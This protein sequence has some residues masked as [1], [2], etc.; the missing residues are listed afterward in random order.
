MNRYRPGWEVKNYLLYLGKRGFP[1]HIG[2]IKKYYSNSVVVGNLAFISGQT[3]TD[4]FTARI[5]SNVFEEQA[6]VALS[7][8]KIALE[9]IGSS[10]DNLIKTHVLVP[11]PENLTVFRRLEMEFYHK[12]APGLLEKPPATTAVHPLNLA[13]TNLQI[14]IE[15][16]AYV[17][18]LPA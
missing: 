1:R 17:P 11:K 13:G 12:Y 15:A 10:L 16:I 5:E 2:E 8:L 7:N 6:K 4:S 3:P 14:E 9:E 18:D